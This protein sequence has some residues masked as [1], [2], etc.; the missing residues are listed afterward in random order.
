MLDFFFFFFF[1]QVFNVALGSPMFRLPV[2]VLLR[3]LSCHVASLYQSQKVEAG[4]KPVLGIV[5]LFSYLC[6]KRSKHV[7][8]PRD[9]DQRLCLSIFHLPSWSCPS[10]KKKKLTLIFSFN[11]VED[12]LMVSFSLWFCRFECCNSVRW[13]LK[14]ELFLFFTSLLLESLEQRFFFF[15]ADTDFDTWETRN[16]KKDAV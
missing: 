3:C 14:V 12:S 15:K 8:A 11:L 9:S 5:K 7:F 10:V 13:P 6:L 16:T 1:Y 4:T 2:L